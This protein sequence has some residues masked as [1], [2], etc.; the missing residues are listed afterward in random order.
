MKERSDVRN[1][2]KRIDEE[3]TA[4]AHL[5]SDVSLGVYKRACWCITDFFV[6]PQKCNTAE[7]KAYVKSHCF[8]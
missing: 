3:D 2:E 6:H 5:K 1:R 4:F 8:M 7:H